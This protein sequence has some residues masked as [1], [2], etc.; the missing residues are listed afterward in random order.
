MRIIKNNTNYKNTQKTYEVEC[1]NCGSILEITKE[2][3]YIGY[4]GSRYIKCPCCEKEMYIEEIEGI[5]LTK[6]NIEF[7]THFDF[8]N[9]DNA[10][11]ISEEEITKEIKRGIKYLEES[12]DEYDYFS[13][14]FGDL[15]L[16]ILPNSGNEYHIIV[17]K[18]YYYGELKYNGG[19]HK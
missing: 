9:K 7:P 6:D 16:V 17:T 19:E 1:E 18:D 11:D 15:Y 14:Q 4:L 2:D 10:K 3:T 5:L 8:T 13:T 12:P